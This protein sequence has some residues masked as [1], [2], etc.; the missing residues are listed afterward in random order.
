MFC[1]WCAHF[2]PTSCIWL[3]PH[4]IVGHLHPYNEHWKINVGRKN[5]VYITLIRCGHIFA[6]QASFNAT[7]TTSKP[8]H[9]Q[10]R[11]QE[12]F[13]LAIARN[14]FIH[15]DKERSA[16]TRLVIKVSRLMS[17]MPCC[18]P[19]KMERNFLIAHHILLLNIG[20]VMNAFRC[21]ESLADVCPF[22]C[23]YRLHAALYRLGR[24]VDI[25]RSHVCWWKIFSFSI[26]W[27]AAF[28]SNGKCEIISSAYFCL[29]QRRSWLLTNEHQWRT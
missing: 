7:T 12:Y 29:Y 3:L 18:R 19:S 25:K 9:H 17:A 11:F 6:T 21:G 5:A 15:H 16:H 10:S 26:M 24:N 13:L 23:A 2:A 28:C 20:D 22:R 1:P 8:R 4:P 27:L 14:S